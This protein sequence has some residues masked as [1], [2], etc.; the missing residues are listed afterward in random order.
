MNLGDGLLF[1]LENG[2]PKLILLSGGADRNSA[3]LPCR[4]RATKIL[5]S[6][7]LSSVDP[8][9]GD[10][11][12]AHLS[13]GRQKEAR[14]KTREAAALSASS[15]LGRSSALTHKPGSSNKLTKGKPGGHKHT[16]SAAS[17]RS[18]WTTED[19]SRTPGGN[20][21][22]LQQEP[23]VGGDGVLKD[24]VVSLAQEQL[25]QILNTVETKR[26]G[27]VE[28][29]GEQKE[30]QGN[31]THFQ[32][33]EDQQGQQTKTGESE[34]DP[35]VDLQNARFP[36]VLFSWL[37]ER[38]SES[39][40]SADARKAHWRRELGTPAHK[41]SSSFTYSAPGSFAPPFLL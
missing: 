3:K 20:K 38:Q 21:R 24:S 31:Q 29:D 26:N 35:L 25:Q 30:S 9:Q 10:E 14:T 18:N 12:F 8:L 5:S 13:L 23:V 34:S 41:P 22:A 19:N 32:K 6:R 7:Q 39:K 33:E 37:D 1:E 28:E 15:T 11:R 36:G 17:P 27:A 4:P 40:H 2:K 16:V